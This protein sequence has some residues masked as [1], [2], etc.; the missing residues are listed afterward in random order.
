MLESR[1]NMTMSA[2]ILRLAFCVCETMN[3]VAEV[4]VNYVTSKRFFLIFIG[5]ERTNMVAP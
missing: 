2:S 3:K 5:K 4:S 1:E